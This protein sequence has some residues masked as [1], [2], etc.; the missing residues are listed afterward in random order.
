M[1]KSKIATKLKRLFLCTNF[2][3]NQMYDGNFVFLFFENQKEAYDG[4]F[5]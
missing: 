3:T 5:E 2:N 4:N 1:I